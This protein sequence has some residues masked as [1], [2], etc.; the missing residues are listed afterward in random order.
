MES[1][2]NGIL[3]WKVLSQ[4]GVLSGHLCHQQLDNTLCPPLTVATTEEK[5]RAARVTTWGCTSIDNAR[6]LLKTHGFQSRLLNRRC[7][8]CC[9]TPPPPR[10]SNAPNSVS[11]TSDLA[12][13]G[14]TGTAGL[15]GSELAPQ[16]RVAILERCPQHK[17]LPLHKLRLRDFRFTGV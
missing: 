8:S 4:A 1:D 11:P 13:L 14:R 2:Q 6:K 7:D 5:V 3:S 12:R 17:S 15:N 10:S 16:A 9:E